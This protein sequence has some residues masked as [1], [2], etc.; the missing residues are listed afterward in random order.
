MPF[1]IFATEIKPK[2][3]WPPGRESLP[4]VAKVV[5]GLIQPV[6]AWRIKYI[7]VN[8]VLKGPSFMRHVGRD[9]EYFARPYD[10]FL[11]VYGKLQRAFKNVRNLLIVMMME[12]DVRSL[13]HQDASEHE[14]LAN[15]HFAINQGIQFFAFNS[16]PRNV[17]CFWRAAHFLSP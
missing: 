11:A 13:F 2:R 10:D 9:A 1:L 16:V 15:E 6:F 5:V 7:K 3:V 4:A 8:R 14:F 12:R 17:F